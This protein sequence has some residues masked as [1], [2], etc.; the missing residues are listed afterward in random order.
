[1]QLLGEGGEGRTDRT[2]YFGLHLPALLL[3]LGRDLVGNVVCVTCSFW[4]R[5][6]NTTEIGGWVKRGL[7]GAA[8]KGGARGVWGCVSSL[9]NFL[10]A[11]S[12]EPPAE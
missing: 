11:A 2:V 12:G 7:E 4:V 1:M 6:A 8:G 5:K 9:S 3:S 10:P